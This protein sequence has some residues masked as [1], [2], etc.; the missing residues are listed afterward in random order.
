MRWFSLLGTT[1]AMLA[2]ACSSDP[3][4]TTTGSDGGGP[5][6]DASPSVDSGGGMDSGGDAGT[7]T[8]KVRIAHLSPDA[9]AVD[10][11][12]KASSSQSW[13]SPLL[14]G[15]GAPSG[16]AYPEVT[17][18][19]DLPAGTYDIRVVAANADCSTGVVPDT[20]GVVVPGNIH[21]T[22]A[23]TGLAGGTPAFALAVYVDDTTVT[24]GKAK[25][26]FVHASPGTPNVDVGLLAGENFTPV[27][28]DVA[29]RG[30]E[31]GG[32]AIDANGYL[33]TDPLTN[34]TLA[35]RATGS[36]SD[37]LTIPGANLPA[38]AI[39]TAFAIGQLSGPQPLKVRLCVDNAPAKGLL[40]DCSTV[41]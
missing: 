38:N 33:A 22:I 3:A 28:T 16:L 25:L 41:P 35:A 10:A 5:G 2:M 1:T 26:R 24:S 30:I 23:A 9:P 32:G 14:K 4:T 6:N 15:L 7:P 36:N 21:A 8:S 34:V 37:A 19:V 31:T 20:N 27:F 17:T 12:V 13:G 18:Y 39:A 40:S 29:F 11:C